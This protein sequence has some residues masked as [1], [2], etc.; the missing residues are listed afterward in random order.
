MA[1]SDGDTSGLSIASRI[2]M[3]Q[4]NAGIKSPQKPLVQNYST[5]RPGSP[6]ELASKSTSAAQKNSKSESPKSSPKSSP[7]YASR[8]EQSIPS[9]KASPKPVP[10]FQNKTKETLSS[11]DKIQDDRDSSFVHKERASLPKPP[12]PN[13]PQFISRHISPNDVNDNCSENPEVPKRTSNLECGERPLVNK[14][15]PEMSVENRRTSQEDNAWKRISG[16]PSRPLPPAPNTQSDQEKDT[17]NKSINP[18]PRPRGRS[19][20]DVYEIVEFE[21][22][23][24]LQ[25]KTDNN[26][27]E[28]EDPNSCSA[29]Q[30]DNT[31]V[32]LC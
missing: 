14:I 27:V 21:E 8:P 19:K 7:S 24:E 3:Y 20:Q 22:Q 18:S 10:R 6:S 11:N 25:N 30:G 1:E 16:P 23:D 2:R 13:K 15:S 12:L 9:P 17:Q 26:D 5:G 32:V 4:N 31:V 29:P 28:Y